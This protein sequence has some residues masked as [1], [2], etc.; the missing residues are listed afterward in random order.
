M[1][2]GA[3]GAIT[4]TINRLKGKFVIS[5]GVMLVNTEFLVDMAFQ[6]TPVLCLTGF[7]TADL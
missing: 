7:G 3:T 1:I 2:D 4:Q 6:Y 5:S